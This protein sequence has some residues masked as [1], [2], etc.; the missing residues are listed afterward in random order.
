MQT[1]KPHDPS[2]KRKLLIGFLIVWELFVFISYWWM[3]Q[4]LW[5]YTKICHGLLTADHFYPDFL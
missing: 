2:W 5:P 4:K 1:E 3:A